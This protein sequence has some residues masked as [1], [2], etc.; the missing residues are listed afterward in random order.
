MM[1]LLSLPPELLIRILRFVGP[2][3]FQND[4]RRLSISRSWYSLARPI[5]FETM[6]LNARRLGRLESQMLWP[7]QEYFGRHCR[8]LAITLE[9]CEENSQLELDKSDEE[10]MAIPANQALRC[11]ATALQNGG[12]LKALDIRTLEAEALHLTDDHSDDPTDSLDLIPER[13]TLSPSSILCYLSL[14]LATALEILYL[15]LAGCA[16]IVKQG[17]HAHYCPSIAMLLPRLIHARIRLPR[18]CPD[19]FEAKHKVSQEDAELPQSRLKTLVICVSFDEPTGLYTP[20]FSRI[21][22]YSNCCQTLANG[23]GEAVLQSVLTGPRWKSLIDSVKSLASRSSNLRTAKIVR[24]RGITHSHLIAFDC[25]TDRE[26]QMAEDSAWDAESIPTEEEES[27]STESLTESEIA[28]L[29]SDD[30]D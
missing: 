13:W 26:H 12:K 6:K 24:H 18:I 5:M 30:E 8:H 10:I 2:S 1:T 14:R 23:E 16:R 17:S 3:E 9:N 20:G 21:I 4:V 27:S 7:A 29:T 22:K 28:S 19:C 15:D 25:L 11:V